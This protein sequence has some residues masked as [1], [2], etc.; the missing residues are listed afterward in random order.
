MT[1]IVSTGQFLYADKLCSMTHRMEGQPDGRTSRSF[2][3]D[4]R[5]I[6]VFANPAF[7]RGQE[8]VAMAATGVARFIPNVHEH[9]DRGDD[10]K[11]L[12]N[13]EART[14]LYQVF[15]DTSWLFVTKEGTT[16]VVSRNQKTSTIDIDTYE[17]VVTLGA[18]QEYIKH[19]NSLLSTTQSLTP[20]EQM[21]LSSRYSKL[22][23]EEFDYFSLK[24][25]QVTYDQKLSERQVTMMIAK[26]NDRICIDD[27][28]FNPSYC[29]VKA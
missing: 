11:D 27:G 6:K 21:V 25:G 28:A 9:L 17:G 16:I 20:L 19:I 15:K 13:Y 3:N 29:S 5:K 24:T 2:V 22:V 18:T 8:V 26:I 12:I 14:G 4:I 7:V 23:S 1:F 10:F